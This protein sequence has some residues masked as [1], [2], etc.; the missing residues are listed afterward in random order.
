MFSYFSLLVYFLAQ[1]NIVATSIYCHTLH[2]I[3][4]V[5]CVAIITKCNTSLHCNYNMYCNITKKLLPKPIAT[6]LIATTTNKS[7]FVATRRNC[8]KYDPITTL[9]HHCNILNF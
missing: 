4:T 2:A 6:P 9:F 8:H 1:L 3:G 7:D 5:L